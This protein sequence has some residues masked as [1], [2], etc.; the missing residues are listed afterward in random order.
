MTRNTFA[1]DYWSSYRRQ[2]YRRG[3]LSRR[4]SPKAAK[5]LMQNIAP[6]AFYGDRWTPGQAQQEVGR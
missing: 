2:E 3:R 6:V 1:P 5:F 4:M